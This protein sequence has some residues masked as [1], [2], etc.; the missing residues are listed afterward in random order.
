[1]LKIVLFVCVSVL[2]LGCKPSI[3]P[4]ALRANFATLDRVVYLGDSYLY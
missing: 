3:K 2:I 4:P 1:M